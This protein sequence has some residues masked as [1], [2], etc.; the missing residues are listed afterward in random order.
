MLTEESLKNVI[1]ILQELRSNLSST[2]KKEQE[3]SKINFCIDVLKEFSNDYNDWAKNCQSSLSISIPSL[4]TLEKHIK[5]FGVTDEIYLYCARILRE[6]ILF[7]ERRYTY[8]N[9]L[10]KDIDFPEPKEQRAALDLLNKYWITF[11]N[12]SS[13]VIHPQNKDLLNYII[14]GHFDIDV[15]NNFLG[16]NNFQAFS[17]FEKNLAQITKIYSG[18]E[19]KKTELENLLKEKEEKVNTLAK[20]LEEQNKAFNFVGLSKG[21]EKLLSKKIWAKRGSFSLMVLIFLALISLPFLFIGARFLNWFQE[22]NIQ[23]SQISWEHMLPVL[24]L[25]FVLIYFFRVVLNHYNS[26]QTQIM[27]IELRQALCQFIQSYIDYAKEIKE[28]E[29]GGNSLEKFENLIFSNIL[30]S[31]DKVPSTFDGVEQLAN[32]INSLKGKS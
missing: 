8:I 28:K 25:E 12:N 11:L 1:N 7:S 27:Q 17:K 2:D 24:G 16:G 31:P 15:I 9:L 20:K 21:F 22:Y 26:I 18:I 23:W 10:M 13:N 6:Y 14:N 3:L 32:M 19:S 29:H 4:F 5:K 30:S